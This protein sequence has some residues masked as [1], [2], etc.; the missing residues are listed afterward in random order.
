[1]LW[2]PLCRCYSDNI[3]SRMAG[4]A[5]MKHPA[6]ESTEPGITVSVIVPCY[7]TA[8]FVGETLDSV[9]D[10]K[11]SGSVEIIVIN[12]GSPDTLILR[13]VLAPYRDSIRY[14]E[15]ENRGLAGAR[16]AGIRA[17]H[18]RYI[19]FL[20]SDD[21]WLPNYLEVMVRTLEENPKAAAAFP[22]VVVFGG[23]SEDGR[24]LRVPGAQQDPI[25]FESLVVGRSWINAGATVRREILIGYGM[26]D[27]SFRQ[28]EDFELWVRMLH[29][30]EQI[31]Y[32]PEVLTRYRRWDGS[33]SSNHRKMFATQ[34]RVL[35]KTR[36]KLKL[37]PA[38]AAA[39]QE[40]LSAVQ[41]LARWEEGRMAFRQRNFF[42]ARSAFT[43]AHAIRPSL[44]L[45][46]VIALLGF[47][48]RALWHTYRMKT[49]VLHSA[50]GGGGGAA[51][52]A[53]A[54]KLKVGTSA[55]SIT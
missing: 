26:F 35:R 51:A 12:D 46:I 32:V 55:G 36:S 33:L 14:I 39:V 27:S 20:D 15:Q 28:V 31:I 4:E 52:A 34:L 9:L 50:G 40:R 22:D 6:G 44:K 45:R 7:N 37:S 49:R 17:A 53:S 5:A 47:A 13:Q 43:A 30:G 24:V 11:F 8:H 1:V 10:Q 16:N 25:T 38:Q 41:M 19:A 3:T 18:G 21:A 48:P 42:M 29:G 23:S 2:R 54:G